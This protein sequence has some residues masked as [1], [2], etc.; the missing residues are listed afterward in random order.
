MGIV[1]KTSFQD[2]IGDLGKLYIKKEFTGGSSDALDSID[3]SV[4]ENGVFALVLKDGKAHT[5]E[6]V[7]GASGGEDPPNIVIPDSNPT[8]RWILRGILYDTDASGAYAVSS[9]PEA[10]EIPLLNNNGQLWLRLN[11]SPILISG[12]DMMSRT[13]Y[14]DAVN[15]DDD[16][17]G[18]SSAPFRTIKKACDSVPVGGKGL[19]YLKG[20]SDSVTP[21]EYVIDTNITVFNKTLSFDWYENKYV[22]V[23]FQSFVSLRHSDWRMSSY[24][25]SYSL[26]I[27]YSHPFF[28]YEG[29][30]AL[31]SFYLIDIEFVNDSDDMY[32]VVTTYSNK[33]NSPFGFVYL[34]RANVSVTN[35]DNNIYLWHKDYA[36]QVVSE[37]WECTFPTNP[38]G[39]PFDN[40]YKWSS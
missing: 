14:V 24:D 6:Y 28:L 25:N 38:S 10:N 30:L 35:S 36:G 34:A 37:V 13:F 19:I 22:R 15:G 11:Q 26:R 5:M 3:G 33:W 12:Q 1:V 8:G 27:E 40:G 17:D 9:T 18:S 7:E 20:S 23:I 21:V 2:Q 16:N 39:N 32:L 29:Y 4:L 31:G